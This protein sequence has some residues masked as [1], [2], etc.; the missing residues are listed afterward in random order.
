MQVVTQSPRVDRARI[1]IQGYKST[2][3][4]TVAPTLMP[5]GNSTGTLYIEPLL[6]PGT[7]FTIAITAFRPEI[8]TTPTATRTP[9]ATSTATAPG[10]SG[11]PTRTSTPS[12][13]PVPTPT[14]DPYPFKAV[15][16]NLGKDE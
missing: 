8:I 10:A 16:P 15:A 2:V 6:A 12:P 9:T 11:T 3:N 1:A 4:I 7:V 14:P 5:A 13:T